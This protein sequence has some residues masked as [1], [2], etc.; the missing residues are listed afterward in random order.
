MEGMDPRHLGMM[1]KRAMQLQDY[2]DAIRMFS[3]GLAQ[4]ESLNLPSQF[5]APFLMDR[6]ECFWQLGDVDVALRE[7]ENALQH[8]LP[9]ADF[10]AEVRLT[11]RSQDWPK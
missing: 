7:M 11:S 3:V 8:G 4:V 9:R 1:G 5:A 6:A 10:F 2:P